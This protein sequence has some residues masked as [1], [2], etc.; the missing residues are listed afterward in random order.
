MSKGLLFWILMILWF[1][2]GL[3]LLFW[4][5]NEAYY[6]AG[7]MLLEFVLFVILGWATFGPPV[8]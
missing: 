4:P 2:F 7:P 8:K 5:R 3:G 6:R 1:I